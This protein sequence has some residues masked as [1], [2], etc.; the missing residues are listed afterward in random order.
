MMSARPQFTID[1]LYVQHTIARRLCIH[2]NG[3]DLLNTTKPTKARWTVVGVTDKISSV[4]MYNTMKNQIHAGAQ[5][6]IVYYN[7]HTVCCATR[8]HIRTAI[9]IKSRI[10]LFISVAPTLLGRNALLHALAYILYN[11]LYT[12]L[13]KFPIAFL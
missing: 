8:G 2:D 3:R 10:P 7:I 4:K 5:H 13:Y 12:F 6:I 11:I 1:I 9:N